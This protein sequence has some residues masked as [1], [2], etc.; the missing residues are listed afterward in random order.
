MLAFLLGEPGGERLSQET[1]PLLL[2]TVNL[3]EVL[4]A[5]HAWAAL[6][7]GLEIRLIR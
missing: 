3:T 6:D 4:T 5:D 1:G 2:S 7:V